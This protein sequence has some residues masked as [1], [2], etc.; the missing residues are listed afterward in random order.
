MRQS[1]RTD[2]IIAFA[3]EQLMSVGEVVVT[4]HAIFEHGGFSGHSILNN[5][6]I[7]EVKRR[8][9]IISRGRLNCEGEIIRIKEGT[10]LRV[11]HFIAN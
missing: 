3:V 11:V 5:Y 8:L 2:R 4:D 9:E 7:P 1:G 10:N 6:F